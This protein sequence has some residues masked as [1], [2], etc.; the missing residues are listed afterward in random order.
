M[1]GCGGS[2]IGR[3]LAGWAVSIGLLMSLTLYCVGA[4]ATAG[5]LTP[6]PIPS[7]RPPAPAP[8]QSEAPPSPSSEE[9]T[10]TPT[11]EES[12]REQESSPEPSTM[13][14][15]EPVRTAPP[16]INPEVA[17]CQQGQ[18]ASV[19]EDPPV[20]KQLG[21]DKAWSFSAGDEVVVAVVDSGVDASNPHL[22]D[23]II[24]GA[25][26]LGGGDG[27]IDEDGHGTAVAGMIAAR[28]VDGSKLVG[29]AKNAKIMPIRVYAG[30]SEQIISEGR[31]PIAERTARGIRWA[32]EN[33]AKVIVVAHSQVENNPDLE[34]AVKDA[35]GL[36]ALVVAGVGTPREDAYTVSPEERSASPTVK[37]AGEDSGQPRYPAGYAEVLGVTALESGGTVSEKVNHGPHVDLAI[38]AQ[39]IPAAFFDEGDCLV[40]RDSPSPS[41]AAGYGAGI[42]TLI[43]ATYPNESPAEWKYRM[44]VTALRPLPAES[45]P[46]MGWGVIAPYAALNFVNDGTALGPENP[47]GAVAV[48]TPS[49][50]AAVPATADP[51]VERR[52]RVATL[53]GAAGGVALALALL[54]ARIRLAVLRRS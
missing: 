50:I 34:L 15:P 28:Q 41:M 13:P 23:A 47:K 14:A 7:V 16:A 20:F 29:I 22:T 44:T 46:Q 6:R 27:T 33:G 26:L 53:F 3:R 24:P 37:Q 18:G 4:T 45:S 30:V 11:A 10:E 49:M 1:E 43:V 8:T 31:G 25:D 42:A 36:G 40:S 21:M 39:G 54:G 19:E 38:P 12:S 2:V 5:V 48:S 9:P 35:A 52:A 32:A 17:D 51:G